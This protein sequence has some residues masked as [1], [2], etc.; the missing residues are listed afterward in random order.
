MFPVLP[1]KEDRKKFSRF[2]SPRS[3]GF[4]KVAASCGSRTML[5][6]CNFLSLGKGEGEA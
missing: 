5:I 2:Q 4:R 3:G 6:L 1:F